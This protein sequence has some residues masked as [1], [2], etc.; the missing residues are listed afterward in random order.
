MRTKAEVRQC[1]PIYEF[2]PLVGLLI[3]TRVPFPLWDR[4]PER[5]SREGG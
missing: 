3:H 1:R 4:V 5:R 2:M